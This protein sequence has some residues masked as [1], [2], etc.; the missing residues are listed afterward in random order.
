MIHTYNLFAVNVFQ[1]KI[2]VPIN[3]YKKILNFVEEKY[4]EKDTISCV[5]GFQYHENFNGKKELDKIINKHIFNIYNLKIIHGWLNVL[6][7]QSYNKPH[8]H[9]ADYI[10]M[11]GVLYLSNENNNI[12]FA[13]DNNIFEIKPKLFDCLIF[14]NNLLH[15]VLPEQ[16]A[17]KRICYAFNLN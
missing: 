12:N 14:P 8:V 11:A 15:Y 13:R 2:I 16:R 3:T 7:N 1:S 10:K 17:E 9:L 5:N 6:K 4:E